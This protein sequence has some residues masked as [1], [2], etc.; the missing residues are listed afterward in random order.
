MFVIVN[1][2]TR[3]VQEILRG[4]SEERRLSVAIVIG[5]RYQRRSGKFDCA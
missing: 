4:S 1:T 3:E 2:D 5:V